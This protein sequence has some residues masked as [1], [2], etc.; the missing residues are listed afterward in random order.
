M[1]RAQARQA[2]RGKGMLGNSRGYTLTEMVLVLAIFMI[3]MGV[4]S[5]GFDTALSQV[6]QQAKRM[7]TDIGSVVG[8]EHMRSDLQNA[9]YGLPW[10][11]P[12]SPSVAGYTEVTLADDT[13]P[14]GASFWPAGV[15]PR[16]FNDAPSGVPR[17]VLSTNTNFNLR[18]GVGSR[19]LVVKSLTVLPSPVAT[20]W[21]TIGYSDSDRTRPTWNGERDFDPAESSSERLMVLRN[22]FVDGIP[23]RQLQLT[24]A[25]GFSANFH[26]FTTLTLPHSS[27][28]MFQVY[29]LD[30]SSSVRMPFNRADYYVNRPATPPPSCAPN[31]GILYKAVLNHG[32][33]GFTQIPLLDCVAD[34][35]VVYG[36]GPAGS[37]VVNNHQITPPDDGSGTGAVV[38]TAKE[39]REQLKEI[40]VYI[41]AHVGKKDASYQYPATTVDVGESFGGPLLGRNFDLAAQIGGD[42]RNYRWKL[43]TIVVR[44]QNLIQ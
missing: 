7:E 37:S 10:A 42:W 16:S 34:M 31:T 22:V 19:Y 27:G 36:T 29:G 25:G 41:L 43:Y 21:V 23:S 14:M 11:F 26:N 3:V 15:N 13:L 33:A 2:A 4:T 30:E 5:R 35:Q 28:D 18:N 32:S 9:G 6:G 17:A 1:M 39:I 38:G 8:L 12:S 24:P 20:K 40:R 44:P